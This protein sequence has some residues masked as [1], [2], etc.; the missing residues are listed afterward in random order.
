MGFGPDTAGTKE[1]TVLIN[2]SAEPPNII[3]SPSNSLSL[4]ILMIRL[5]QLILKAA[6]FQS[7]AT[8]QE[9]MSCWGLVPSAAAQGDINPAVSSVPH[10]ALTALCRQIS[11]LG[12]PGW[13]ELHGTASTAPL[14][15]RF[16]HHFK[17]DQTLKLR[18]TTCREGW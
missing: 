17:R 7:Q 5:T 18:C 13:G 2:V 1:D 9:I 11:A 16:W 6:G 4:H 15:W 12:V 14:L 8:L 10:S 3:T